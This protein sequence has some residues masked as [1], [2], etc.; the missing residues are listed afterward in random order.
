MKTLRRFIPFIIFYSLILMVTACGGIKGN[1]SNQNELNIFG[2]DG[3]VPKEVMEDFEKETGIKVNLST[4]S[5]NEEMYA[6]VTAGKNQ[7]D[8]INMGTYYVETFVK[9]GIAEKIDKNK[10]SI[11]KSG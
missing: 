2:F 8:L 4:F 9:E 1:K 6:K 10:G 5:A 3:D 11:T 7:Y